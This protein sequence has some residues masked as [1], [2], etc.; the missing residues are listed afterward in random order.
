MR[1]IYITLL[2]AICLSANPIDLGVVGSVYDVVESDSIQDLKDAA[3]NIDWAQKEKELQ[4]QIDAQ[5]KKD[6]NLAFASF[7]EKKTV[8]DKFV[9]QYDVYDPIKKKFFRAG[10]KLPVEPFPKGFEALFC[11]IDGTNK[12]GVAKVVQEFGTKCRYVVA[13]VDIRQLQKDFPDLDLYPFDETLAKR[14]NIEYVPTKIRLYEDKIDY[15]IIDYEKILRE[16]KYF[17]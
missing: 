13:N 1:K 17:Q 4:A 11:F 12:K 16:L 7:N 9:V 6:S 5:F 15:T 14:F 2:S 3:K 10:D 8:V